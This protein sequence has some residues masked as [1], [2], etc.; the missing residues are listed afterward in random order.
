MVVKKQP[1]LLGRRVFAKGNQHDMHKD[2]VAAV[3]GGHGGSL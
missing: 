2:G 3:S 1:A